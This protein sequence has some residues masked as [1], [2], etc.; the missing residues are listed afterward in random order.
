MVKK[1][2]SIQL[3]T[4]KTMLMDLKSNDMSFYDFLK[5]DRNST[6]HRQ[7]QVLESLDF[8]T[9]KQS[10]ERKKKKYNLTRK[11]KRFLDLF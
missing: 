6:R 3:D 1:K 9:G 4:A 5:K 10:G 7:L 11:G 2:K 8:V